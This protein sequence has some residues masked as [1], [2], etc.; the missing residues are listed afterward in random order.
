VRDGMACSRA[1]VGW[2]QGTDHIEVDS[3]RKARLGKNL[4]KHFDGLRR[5]FDIQSVIDTVWRRGR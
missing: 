2:L 3:G 4:R 1:C 5:R